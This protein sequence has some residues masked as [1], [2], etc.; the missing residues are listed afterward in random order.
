MTNFISPQENRFKEAITKGEKQYGLW[1][2]LTSNLATEI[3]GAIGYDWLVIDAEH[4]PN[5][6][7][8]LVPQLQA[9]R[10][11]HSEPVVRATWNDTVLIKRFMDIGFRTILVPYVQN[12][13]E[14]AAA[15]AAMRYPPEG[16]RGVATV[17]R[18]SSYGADASYLTTANDR[19][20][21]LVQV[22]TG[23]AVDRIEKICDVKN[24]GGVFIGPADLSASM[25]H[26]GNPGHPDVQSAMKHCADVCKSKGIPIGT[27]APVSAD[28][29][30]YL[31]WG[32]TFV[33]LGAESA[34]MR[35]GAQ[36]KLDEFRNA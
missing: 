22:E 15:V 17:Q 23:N 33:A 2:G 16:V 10:G 31:E 9:L 18:S 13:D 28:A 25:D 30:R 8:T 5:E 34:M 11:S 6:M 7:T 27:L 36:A 29:K 20:C 35:A 19:V 21:T 12:E 32:Y 1:I 4:A 26:L 24:L 3:I 14:A